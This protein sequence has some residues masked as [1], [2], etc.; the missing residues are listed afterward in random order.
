MGIESQIE[1]WIGLA[2]Y[3]FDTARAMLKSGRF[4]Y[5]VFTCQQ[6]VEKMLKAIYV[7]TNKVTPPYTHNLQKLANENLLVDKMS[8]AQLK[9]LDKLNTFY[10]EGR[11]SE[12]LAELKS[13][14]S[15]QAATDIFNSTKI[16]YEW[17]KQQLN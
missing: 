6:C 10:I 5:V 1:N 4:L 12:Q 13:N 15:E 7:K 14:I 9:F 11:Y 8:E 3:D 16:F 2:E 17:L